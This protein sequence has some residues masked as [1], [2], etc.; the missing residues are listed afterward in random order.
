MMYLCWQHTI[1][2]FLPGT[3]P[4]MYVLRV[5]G[6]KV[7]SPSSLMRFFHALVASCVGLTYLRPCLLMSLI[8][9]LIQ[10]PWISTDDGPLERSVGPCGPY[11][12]NLQWC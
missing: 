2:T 9:S 12:W 10:R 7:A 11:R 5:V 4:P 1:S 3:V 6:N 8:A